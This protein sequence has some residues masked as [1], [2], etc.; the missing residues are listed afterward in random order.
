MKGIWK[1]ISVVLVVMMC[2]CFAYIDK[3]EAETSTGS[4]YFGTLFGIT[5]DDV[6]NHLSA[7]EGD[8]FYLGTPYAPGSAA[9]SRVPGPDGAMNCGA[10]ISE[11]IG[12]AYREAGN[13]EMKDFLQEF[14]DLLG[15]AA[16]HDDAGN[17]KWPNCVDCAASNWYNLAKKH[18]A[19]MYNFGSGETGKQALLQEAK[20]GDIILMWVGDP[21]NETLD[22][23]NH[24]GIYWG[25]N[26]ENKMWHSKS[27]ENRISEIEIKIGD[28]EYILIPI[29]EPEPDPEPD[30]PN[31]PKPTTFT[32]TISKKDITTKDELPGAKIV[33]RDKDGKEVISFVSGPE[34]KRIT[35]KAG[36]YTLK[37]T[38]TPSPLQ[39]CLDNLK[40]DQMRESCNYN[41]IETELQFE[42]TSNGKVKLLSKKDEHYQIDGTKIT[43]FNDT[44]PVLK[45][46][47]TGAGQTILLIFMGLLTLGSGAFL[48]YQNTKRKQL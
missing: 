43:V 26:G 10:F 27:P 11:V 19:I 1:K 15:D 23:D 40:E 35:L 29:G 12:R 48:V 30:V 6:V 7:H 14:K 16:W 25:D 45:V 5:R 41:P 28:P 37:E 8:D 3:A 21:Q 9:T 42:V 46:P 47:D 22:G 39:S 18:N 13:G 2:L 36:V 31:P 34:E 20:K 24:M 32:I 38:A 33:I 17:V 4:V 44:T